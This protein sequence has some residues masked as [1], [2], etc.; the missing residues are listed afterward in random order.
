MFT[1]S[2]AAHSAST[3]DLDFSDH[4]YVASRLTRRAAFELRAARRP[5]TMAVLVRLTEPANQS[6]MVFIV[7]AARSG[8]T[9]LQTAL[10]T[11]DDVFLLGEAFF[12][13]ENLRPGFRA[14][15][16]EKHRGFAYAPSK[17]NDCPAVAPE[18]AT[19]VETIAALVSR[20]RLV[21]DKISF[22]GYKAGRWP[23]EFLA[24]HRRYFHGAAYILMFRNPR[25]AI[26]S[27]RSSWGIENLVPWARSYIAAQRALIRLRVNF[28]RTVPVILETVE[29]ATFESI[30]QCLHLR[31]PPL[32]SILRR[33]DVSPDDQQSVPIELR[34]TVDGLEALYPALCQAVAGARP[35]RS[36]AR[37]DS[38][39][40][41]LAELYRSLDPLHYSIG[42]RIAR[43]RS[44]VVTA[45]RLVRN[46]LRQ[47]A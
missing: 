42:A 46:S 43:L 18:N 27:P 32:S 45:S 20:H 28:P 19:W 4:R 12:F 22:G 34:E 8:T 21:G 38:I 33:M 10:N 29:T 47:T 5:S 39:D 26:L 36:E 40:I 7:G 1:L 25:D 23:S 11:S 24:F 13:W 16:N 44:R 14:R 41:R 2:S 17:Q 3:R 35:L 6:R 31:I 15:Y 9:A 37:L 30:E